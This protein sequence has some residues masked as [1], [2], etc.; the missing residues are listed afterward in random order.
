MA[1]HALNH[2][3]QALEQQGTWQEHR[4]FQRLLACWNQL[5]GDAVA[6]RTRPVGIQK[7]VLRVAVCNAVWAQ[8][9]AF[10]RQ[11]ILQKLNGML[12][13]RPLTDIRFSTTPWH[14]RPASDLAADEEGTDEADVWRSH[15]SRLIHQSG[16]LPQ[17]PSEPFSSNRLSDFSSQEER[18]NPEAV[19]QAWAATMQRRSQHLPL[20]P[21]CQCPAPEGEIKRWAAC[22]LCA[23]KRW[24]HTQGPEQNVNPNLSD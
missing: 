17:Q 20:C 5:V 15:P 1:L 24:K 23:A 13:D 9:L 19:F 10:E 6:A 22:S 16:V 2:L 8:N 3:I 7:D 21:Q 11:R 18:R 14:A 12:G 4:R